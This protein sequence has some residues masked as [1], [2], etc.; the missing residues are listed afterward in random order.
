MRVAIG[1]LY[2]E[3]NTFVSAPTKLADFQA[4]QF[5]EG[6]DLFELKSTRSEIGGFLVA[7][8]DQAWQVQPALF[9]A[10]LPSGPVRDE[11]YANLS[12][13]LIDGLVRD[14]TPDAVLLCL[15]GAMA[16]E[17]GGDADGEL[18]GRV[19]QAVG[20]D[21]PIVATL[22][23]HSNT[24]DAMAARVDALVA[25]DTYP[26]VDMYDRGY[27]AAGVLKEVMLKGSRRAVV[28]RK[29][30]L[31]TAPQVQYTGT[32]P[33]RTIM[34]HV[35]QMEAQ[36][37]AL[38]SVTQGF[39]YADTD[40][41]GMSVLVSSSD[42]LAAQE[43]AALAVKEIQCH[44]DDFAFSALSVEAAVDRA[45]NL[46]GPVVLVDSADNVGGGAP[47]DG[48]AILREWLRRDGKGLVVALTDPA[49]VAL[50]SSAGVGSELTLEV[51][52]KTDRRH[53]EP[54]P[55][56]CRV[57]LISDGRYVH[58]GSYNN[59][60]VTQMGRSAVVEASGNVILLTERRVMPFDA[61]QLFSVGI[62]PAYCHAL[63]V[64]SAIAWRA[65]YGEIAK[66]VIEVDS[67]GVCTANLHRLRLH[68]VNPDTVRPMF[69]K[70]TVPGS[71]GLP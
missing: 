57:R 29:A 35:H 62:S 1:G 49:S 31:V 3:T 5:F 14:G 10:A 4:Y 8:E 11:D 52:G 40:C 47:G 45:L 15:H 43:I 32:G 6:A 68:T 26:H 23:L 53:G 51:G 2:H 18:L 69:S 44:A 13:R 71:D 25:Y 46:E 36:S 38:I 67:P 59:G 16:T 28:H 58:R 27:E 61:Q 54:V 21:V 70:E 7:C 12:D 42:H 39:P 33:M 19:A 48:T 9:A 66:E 65:A 41:L 24:S 56:K 60:F 50:A 22:D 34:Q 17:S 63:V 55:L 37:G 20:P 30:G 64:K